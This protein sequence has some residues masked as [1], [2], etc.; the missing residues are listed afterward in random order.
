MAYSIG[1]RHLLV[2]P[3]VKFLERNISTAVVRTIG[4]DLQTVA[5][6]SSLAV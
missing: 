6:G 4:R 2:C 1:C 3:K 5:I